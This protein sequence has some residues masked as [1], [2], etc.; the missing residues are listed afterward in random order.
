MPSSIPIMMQPP[1]AAKH[2][3]KTCED[4]HPKIAH[5]TPPAANAS[6]TLVAWSAGRVLVAASVSGVLK[7]G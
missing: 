3:K 1:P 2:E 5:P 6:A 4:S 7:S